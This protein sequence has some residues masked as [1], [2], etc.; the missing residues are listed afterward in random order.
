M[1]VFSISVE[2]SLSELS[3]SVDIFLCISRI[4]L[5]RASISMISG[6]TCLKVG[7]G[8]GGFDGQELVAEMHVQMRACNDCNYSHYCW[9][10]LLIKSQLAMQL[11]SLH[12]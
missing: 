4:H 8:G 1:F 7:G 5:H 2:S 12:I 11:L 10:F 6:R 9:M 3:E